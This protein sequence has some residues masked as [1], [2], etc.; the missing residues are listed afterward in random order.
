M[1]IFIFQSEEHHYSQ[2]KHH[3]GIKDNVLPN[4]PLSPKSPSKDVLNSTGQNLATISN[5]DIDIQPQEHRDKLRKV[6][7]P[8]PAIS[9]V[10]RTEREEK[11]NQDTAVP[12]PHPRK[13]AVGKDERSLVSQTS[14]RTVPP[15]HVERSEPV[16]DS[17]AQNVNTSEQEDT[18]KLLQQAAMEDVKTDKRDTP[19]AREEQKTEAEH[20][21]GDKVV[22][23]VIHRNDMKVEHL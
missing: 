12:Q 10:K 15:N 19:E 20:R 14:S 7:P 13:Q 21:S 11:K 9:T 8:R 4:P 3:N 23:Y 6:K 2:S 17:R 16:K 1:S 18:M 5:I 22:Q